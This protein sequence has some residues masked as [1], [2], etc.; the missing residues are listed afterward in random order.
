MKRKHDIKIGR[1]CILRE[2]RRPAVLKKQW[3]EEEAVAE[4]IRR[5]EAVIDFRQ[6]KDVRVVGYLSDYDP[7]LLVG[8]KPWPGLKPR[9]REEVKDGRKSFRIKRYARGNDHL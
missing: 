4:S 1:A 6:T 8:V 9:N 5:Y 3:T 2:W 7:R